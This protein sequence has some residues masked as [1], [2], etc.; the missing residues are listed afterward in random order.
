VDNEK[1]ITIQGVVYEKEFTPPHTFLN[2]FDGAEVRLN[3][4]YEEAK[5]FL[6]K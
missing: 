4:T 5:K 6:G 2:N 3:I 1:F